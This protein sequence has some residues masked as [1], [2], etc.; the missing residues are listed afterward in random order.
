MIV[1]LRNQKHVVLRRNKQLSY[2]LGFILGLTICRLIDGIEF[3][4][5]FIGAKGSTLTDG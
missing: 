2:I 1:I 5:T 3:D 4:M